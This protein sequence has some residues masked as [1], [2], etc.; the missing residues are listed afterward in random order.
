MGVNSV[1]MKIPFKGRPNQ[2]TEIYVTFNTEAA[3]TA[4]REIIADSISAKTFDSSAKNRA[5]T[6]EWL[7]DFAKTLYAARRARSGLI[8]ADCGEPGWDILLEAFSVSAP[9]SIKHACIAA[10]TPPTTALRWI[11]LLESEQC[12]ARMEDP[13]DKRRTLVEL[14]DFGREVVTKALEENAK[15]LS[16]CFAERDRCVS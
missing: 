8:P 9:I 4:P 2:A 15:L 10:D 5:E 7:K 13:S 3:R 16:R 12:L 1:R 14:T 6:S 11:G